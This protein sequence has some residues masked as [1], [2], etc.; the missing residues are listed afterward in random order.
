MVLYDCKCQKGGD[1]S[2]QSAIDSVCACD[3]HG[4]KEPFLTQKEN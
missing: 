2:D 4:M 3:C 1:C